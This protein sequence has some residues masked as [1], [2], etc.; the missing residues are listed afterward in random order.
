MFSG[1]HVQSIIDH[2]L[3]YGKLFFPPHLSLSLSLPL[4]LPAFLSNSWVA[5][6]VAYYIMCFHVA[7]KP[8][9]S[10]RWFDRSFLFLAYALLIFIQS[11]ARMVDFAPPLPHS[12]PLILLYALRPLDNMC[13]IFFFECLKLCTSCSIC[14]HSLPKHPHTLPN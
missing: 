1:R 8:L 10:A 2:L 7:I 4:S 6:T 13:L 11:S 9:R 3:C 12:M 5:Y 14:T